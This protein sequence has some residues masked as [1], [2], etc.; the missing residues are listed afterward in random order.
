MLA[1]AVEA[2]FSPATRPRPHHMWRRGALLLGGGYNG[3]GRGSGPGGEGQKARWRRST[4]HGSALARSA[5]PRRCLPPGLPLLRSRAHLPA[6]RCD[7]TSCRVHLSAG[8]C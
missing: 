5:P 7:L 8:C 1:T 3:H 4:S 2:S 6:G